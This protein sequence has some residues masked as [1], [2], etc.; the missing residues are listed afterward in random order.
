MSPILST[1]FRHV[2]PG[3]YDVSKMHVAVSNVQHAICICNMMGD[4]K[5]N[6]AGVERTIKEV[7]ARQSPT[8][9]GRSER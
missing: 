3:L 8:L 7:Q 5:Y 1:Y 4:D 6:V 2:N 9:P